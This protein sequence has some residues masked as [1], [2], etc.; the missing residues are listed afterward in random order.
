MSKKQHQGKLETRKRVYRVPD[1]GYYLIVTDAVETEPNYLN[2]LKNSLPKEFK[3]RLVIKVKTSKT[4][5]MIETMQSEMA[6]IPNLCEPWLVFDKDQVVGFDELINKAKRKEMNVGWSNPCI[7]ILFLAYFGK[8]PN[9]SESRVCIKEFENEYSKLLNKK[10]KKNNKEIYKE[11]V[12]HG[13]EKSAVDIMERKYEECLKNCMR[14]PSKMNG[15]S[16]VYRL[17]KEIVGKV[18]VVESNHGGENLGHG[19]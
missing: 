18:N 1:M 15:V 14:D 6:K 5:D 2:G 11:L 19:M 12:K 16:M 3:D 13:N 9:I 4:Y 8:S 10:Y 17:V 7:E